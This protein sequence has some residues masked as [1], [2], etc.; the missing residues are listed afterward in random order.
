MNKT[1][2][3]KFQDRVK[4]GIQEGKDY[5]AIAAE[6]NKEGLTL[7]KSGG[8]WTD[9]NVGRYA[10]QISTPRV[11]RSQIQVA[12]PVSHKSDR[13]SAVRAIVQLKGLDVDTRLALIDLLVS[14]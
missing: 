3:R 2:K 10:R 11:V 12:L 13:T 7:P 1:V 14:A 9:H 5:K 8:E 6:M 4:Q